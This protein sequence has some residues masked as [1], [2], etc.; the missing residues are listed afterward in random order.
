MNCLQNV[1]G[2]LIELR[3]A[4]NQVT[5]RFTSFV[6]FNKTQTT[7]GKGKKPFNVEKAQTE[8]AQKQ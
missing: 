5:N 4:T 2:M 3:S 1:G 7:K 6:C 8:K